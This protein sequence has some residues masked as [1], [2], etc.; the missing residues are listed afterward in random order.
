MKIHIVGQ[1]NE[2]I[3]WINKSYTKFHEYFEFRK[4]DRSFVTFKSVPE[5]RRGLEVPFSFIKREHRNREKRKGR[6]SG[7]WGV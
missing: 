5:W 6:N 3:D 1:K 7:P 4:G 2:N